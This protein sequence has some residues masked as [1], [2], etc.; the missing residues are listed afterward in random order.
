MGIFGKLHYYTDKSLWKEIRQL[1]KS[2]S[3]TSLM[4]ALLKLMDKHILSSK[5]HGNKHIR[6][7]VSEVLNDTLIHQ[8]IK[9]IQP[10][11]FT[12]KEIIH[13]WETRLGVSEKESTAGL[14]YNFIHKAGGQI[15]FDQTLQ[16]LHKT[17]PTTE[18]DAINAIEPFITAIQKIMNRLLAR[19]TSEVDNELKAFMGLHLDHPKFNIAR[20]QEFLNESYLNPESIR[21]LNELINIYLNSSRGKDKEKLVNDLIEFHKT[22]MKRRSNLPWITIGRNHSITQHRSFQYNE[23]E[24]EALSDHSWVNNYYLSTLVS[25]YQGLHH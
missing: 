9:A 10:E 17:N 21:R 23:R 18:L 16:S 14:L 2:P 5:V 6:V 24:M 22:L 8:Y 25:L 20:M 1:F 15:D 12:T 4:E 13:F 7:K 19:G 11:H 3:W